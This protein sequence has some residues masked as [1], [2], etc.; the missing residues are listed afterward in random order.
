MLIV[1]VGINWPPIKTNYKAAI[2]TPVSDCLDL[3]EKLKPVIG[4]VA[5]ILAILLVAGQTKFLTTYDAWLQAY[6]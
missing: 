4:Q 5:H 2:N 3:N 6:W 1:M